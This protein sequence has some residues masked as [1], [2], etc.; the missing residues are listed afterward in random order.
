MVGCHGPHRV[1]F[2]SFSGSCVRVFSSAW[3]SWVKLKAGGIVVTYTSGIPSFSP[4]GTDC[5]PLHCPENVLASWHPPNDKKLSSALL[6]LVLVLVV[7][8]VLVLLVLL[9]L[10]EN[11]GKGAITAFELPP[12]C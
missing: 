7:V 6:A 5:A 9:V 1:V 2:F 12:G 10:V 8:V 3:S 11:K 4:S